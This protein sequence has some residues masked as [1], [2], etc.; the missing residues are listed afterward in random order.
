L[1]P[2][3]RNRSF[4]RASASLGLKVAMV[5]GEKNGKA[6]I[7]EQVEK[8]CQETLLRPLAHLVVH[9]G[10]TE[11]HAVHDLIDRIDNQSDRSHPRVGDALLCYRERRLF[12][13]SFDISHFG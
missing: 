9:A 7:E 10:R 1:P 6:T 11:L 4:R 12:T 2:K 5:R 8:P 13:Q 3:I